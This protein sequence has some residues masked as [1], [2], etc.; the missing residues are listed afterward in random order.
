[1]FVLPMCAYVFRH[2]HATN[3]ATA[4]L[5]NLASLS[6]IATY[7]VLAFYCLCGFSFITLLYEEGRGNT[8][9]RLFLAVLPP[10]RLHPI[11]FH[12]MEKHFHMV[13]HTWLTFTRSRYSLF[14]LLLYLGSLF[15]WKTTLIFAG[16]DNCIVDICPC[17]W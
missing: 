9:E 10:A 7:G 5:F 17:S 6:G 13:F 11:L 12:F 15:T 1:M 3:A 8:K 4:S 2:R 16:F 14:W